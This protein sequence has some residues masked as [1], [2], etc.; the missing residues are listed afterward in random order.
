M[1]ENVYGGKDFET[2]VYTVNWRSAHYKNLNLPTFYSI[3]K[4]FLISKYPKLGT[5]PENVIK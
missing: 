5:N 1:C 3:A 4:V 2:A